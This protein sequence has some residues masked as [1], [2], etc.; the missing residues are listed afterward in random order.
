VFTLGAVAAA[1]LILG[2]RTRIAT[3]IGWL[4]IG[5]IQ[6]RNQL[7]LQH[8]DYLLRLLL[9]WSMFLPLGARLSLD[10]RHCVVV[11]QNRFV[12]VAGAALLVQI[13]C[14]YFF[15]G[16]FKLDPVW[17]GGD[18]VGNALRMDHYVSSVG[19]LL[20]PF[21]GVQRLITHFT[22]V[23]ELVAPLLLFVPVATWPVRAALVPLFIAFHAGLALVFELGNFQYVSMAGMLPFVPPPVWDRIFGRED[24]AGRPMLRSSVAAQAVAALVLTYVVVSNVLSFP[25]TSEWLAQ[26]AAWQPI[27]RI[28]WQL[29]LKQEWSIFSAPQPGRSWLVA[30]ATLANGS[31]IDLYRGTAVDRE[32]PARTFETYGDFRW[33]QYVAL[34]ILSPRYTRL[35]PPFATYLC[36]LWNGSHAA[37]ERAA[38]V[39][40][41][42]VDDVNGALRRVPLLQRHRCP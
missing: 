29:M 42:R 3:A 41:Y 8:G 39:G 7:L 19:L 23:F 38:H 18:A 28:G 2:Y 20:R 26:S 33:R 11:P 14:V 17:L 37:N 5:S 24:P 25:R 10:A 34:Y 32:P 16:V 22:L 27:D 31:E 40:L 13:A 15:A 9:F 4:V 6:S 1:M 12:S 35:R 36:R 21:T 30:P